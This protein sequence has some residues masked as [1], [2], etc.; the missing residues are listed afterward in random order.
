MGRLEYSL[1]EEAQLRV[2]EIEAILENDLYDGQEKEKSLIKER[3]RLEMFFEKFNGLTDQKIE[4]M[5]KEFTNVPFDEDTEGRLLLSEDWYLWEKGTWNEDIWK[6]FDENHS[7]GVG[8]L[9]ENRL[10]NSKKSS[11]D[12]KMADAAGRGSKG[13]ERSSERQDDMNR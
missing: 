11:L 7:K 5:W 4:D 3:E 8:W 13:C 6:W 10:S 1:I 9:F 2:T 12:D